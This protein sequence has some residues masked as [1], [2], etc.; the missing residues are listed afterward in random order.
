MRTFI[1]SV[2]AALVLL[3]H[4]SF[5]RYHQYTEHV[6]ITLVP[7]CIL[8]APFALAAEEMMCCHELEHGPMLG[9]TR[10]YISG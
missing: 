2:F 9:A 10:K 8:Q 6:L 4:V 1:Q 5:L 7:S 3:S